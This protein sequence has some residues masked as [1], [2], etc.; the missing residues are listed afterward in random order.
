MSFTKIN[1]KIFKLFLPTNAAAL[2]V[3]MPRWWHASLATISRSDDL[4]TARPSPKREKGVS[5]EPFNCNCHNSPL[6]KHYFNFILIC[7]S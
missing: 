2:V 6:L 5:P 3:G 7:G 4:S 1:K